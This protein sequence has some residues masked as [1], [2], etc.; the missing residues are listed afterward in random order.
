MDKKKKVLFV[1]GTSHASG[2]YRME[3]PC[4]TLQQLGYTTDIIMYNTINP[5]TLIGSKTLLNGKKSYYDLTKSDVVIFQMIWFEALNLVVEGLKSK[6]VFT[7]MEVDDN[8][9]H[10]P[11][12]NPAFWSF[13]PRARLMKNGKGDKEVRIFN[14][15]VNFALDNMFRAMRTVDM[16]QV[17]TPELRELYK[18]LN[19]NIVVLENCVNNSIYDK[20][21]KVVNKK[22]VIMWAGTKTHLDDL[23]LINGCI[24][25]NCKLI[26]G[27]FPEIQDK[28][29]FSNH[30]DVEYLP[31]VKFKD[32]PK[33]VAKADIV[34][35]PLEDTKFNACKSD[36]KGLEFA[37]MRIPCVASDIAPYKRWVE[38]EKNG[39]LVK[40]NKVKFWMKYLKLLV[41]NKAL[42]EKMGREAKKRAVERD[43]NNYISNWEGVYFN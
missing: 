25:E 35:I 27:G 33:M 2:H 4:L 31:P 29:L 30:P 16:L 41:D 11:R 13:H 39:F 19:D 3:L 43:I 15:K 36:I 5:L 23:Y 8:Y 22:P 1:R 6:G 32:Y 40:K 24:P 7:S 9:R 21:E 38:H 37:A 42:R 18:P 26:I 14:E 10:L 12:N 20:I 28:G 34:A 17:S